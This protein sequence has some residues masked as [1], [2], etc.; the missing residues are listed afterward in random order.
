MKKVVIIAIALFLCL[1]LFSGTL[2]AQRHGGFPS[3]GFHGGYHVGGPRIIIGGHFGFPYYYPYLHY[4]YYYRYSYPEPYADTS[5][6]LNIE[7]EQAYYWYYCQDSQG[8]YPYISSCPGGWTRVV[9]TPPPPG[10][11]VR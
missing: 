1:N 4:P 6:P 8:Y 10:E 5:P 2:Y 3:R 7:P 11:G 9:P